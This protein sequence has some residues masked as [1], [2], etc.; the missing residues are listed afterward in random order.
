MTTF[1]IMHN[2]VMED[3]GEGVHHILE[4]EQMGEP[5]KLPEQNLVTFEEFIQMH[6]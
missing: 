3:E 6:Q 5:I 1:V 2:M 4:F